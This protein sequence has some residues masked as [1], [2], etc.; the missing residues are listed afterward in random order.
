LLA[1]LLCLVALAAPLFAPLAA[2]ILPIAAVAA[3]VLLTLARLLCEAGR[4]R[5]LGVVAWALKWGIT[6]GAILVFLALSPLSAL[7]VVILGGSLAAL[8][9]L[10][11]RLGCVVP[12][13]FS[14]P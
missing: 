13:L 12:R 1:V 3:V 8:I 9:H 14:V 2:P 7:V 5:F 4:C 10:M 6:L 11:L